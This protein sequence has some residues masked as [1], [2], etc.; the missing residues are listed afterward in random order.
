MQ[1]IIIRNPVAV[2]ML[3][4]GVYSTSKVAPNIPKRRHSLERLPC[5]AQNSTKSCKVE[6]LTL[7]NIQHLTTSICSICANAT[8]LNSGK[9]F[10]NIFAHDLWKKFEMRCR[11]LLMTVNI[12]KASLVFKSS[13]V[14][15]LEYSFARVNRAA[16][17]AAWNAGIFMFGN[18]SCSFSMTLFRTLCFLPPGA[19]GRCAFATI[20][21]WLV[22]D[23]ECRRCAAI[24]PDSATS[25]LANAAIL[26]M[27]HSVNLNAIARSKMQKKTLLA[28][29]LWQQHCNSCSSW[30]GQKPHPWNLSQSLEKY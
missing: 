12:C 24:Y 21:Q 13:C 10:C 5:P 1:S 9:A 3:W 7:R 27:I 29:L 30:E 22:Q 23:S 14:G 11:R 8:P 16:P 18:F 19:D 4:S 2:I 15:M 25:S 6:R 28:D 20:V 26:W 17:T